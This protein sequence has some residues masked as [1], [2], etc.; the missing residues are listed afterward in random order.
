[1]DIHV[2]HHLGLTI[3]SM[4]V[5]FVGLIML[6]SYTGYATLESENTKVGKLALVSCLIMGCL[7]FCEVERNKL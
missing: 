2:K 3:A 6:K 5:V 7:I 1:M 4:L